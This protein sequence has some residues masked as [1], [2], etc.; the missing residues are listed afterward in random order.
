MHY[1]GIDQGTTGTTAIVFNE[2]WDTCGRG[3]FEHKQFYPKPG[4]VEHDPAELWTRTIESVSVALEQ[5][6]LNARDLRAIG[7]A[8][9]GETCMVWDRR[10]GEPIYNAI[11]WQDRRTSGAADSIRTEFGE[12]VT[13]KTGLPVDAYFSALKIKWILDSVEG[14]W[15]R[16]RNGELRVGTL[17]TWLLWKMTGGELYVTDASTAA[18]TMLFN[19]RTGRWD[20]ELLDIVG[21]PKSILPEIRESVGLFAHTS[22]GALFEAEVPIAG[23]VVDQAAALFGQACFGEGSLKTTY[24]TGCFMLMNTGNAPI[25][26]PNGLITTAVWSIDGVLTYALDGGVYIAGAAIQWLRDGIQIIDSAAETERLANSVTDTAGLHFV[27]AF[28]GL[29]APYWD[30]YARGMMIGITG[31]TTRAHIVRATLEAIAFQVAEN[32]EVMRKDSG[33]PVAAMRADGGAAVNGFLMQFQADILGIPVEV[34]GTHETTALGAAYLAALGVGDIGSLDEISRKWKP[35][36]R[37]EPAMSDDR[38]CE[39]MHQWKR[40]VSRAEKWIEA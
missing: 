39:L 25:P 37:Y 36:R 6:N 11:V 20:E 23:S 19:L 21:I 16:A 33:M 15:T 2:E 9:Q 40:S 3:Y 26:S 4:W 32:L 31:G 24:G 30:Q 10:T 14:A 34:P 18:R 12:L 8:N 38:R 29:A 28:T 13:R 27:P 7:L 22:P 17:D 1:L 35:A 5:S